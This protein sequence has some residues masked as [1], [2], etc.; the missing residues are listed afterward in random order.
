MPPLIASERALP[1]ATATVSTL[2]RVRKW[3][4]GVVDAV[5]LVYGMSLAVLMLT[6]GLDAGWLHIQ[7]A[8]KPILI[9]LLFV[10]VRIALGDQ[11]WLLRPL[12]AMRDA[13]RPVL[14][15]SVARL[16][17]AVRD[18]LFACAATVPAM[19]GVSFLVN[20]LFASGRPRPF[21]LPFAY[22]KFAETFA[23]WDSGWYFDIAKRGY[24][25]LPD[26]QSS[27]PFFPLYPLAMRTLASVFGGSDQA[28]WIS[29]IVI[30]CVSFIAGLVVLH[31]LTERICGDREVA[32]R[33]VLFLA[34]YPFSFFL[35][36]VYPG[37]LFFL[38]TVLAI[39]AAFSSRWRQ[40]GL[41]GA[42]ATLTRPHGILIAL[43]LIVLA[44]RGGTV[45]Q[46][47]MRIVALAPIPAALAGFSL[48]VAHLT[49]DPLAWLHAERA[50]GYSLWQAPWQQLLVLFGDIGQ[51]GLYLYFFSSPLAPFRLFHGA[52]ALALLMLVPTIFR[53]LGVALGAYV[54]VNL[55][56]P[57]SSN[58]LEG[59]GRY[60][61]AWF[62]IF[63]VMGMVGSPRIREAILVTSSLLLA[64]F[65]GLF[66]TWQPIY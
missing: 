34:V 46:I 63:M 7:H 59:I 18:A 30:S 13:A 60:A 58:A 12:R 19:C 14:T 50:W 6:G 37:G 66:V 56:V 3:T 10:P 26:Q 24:F 38:L 15:S 32:R 52:I 47:A 11:S 53:R 5:I 51:R 35:T 55:L 40:A 4:V 61:A 41:W 62:P 43:P 31:T 64:L 22:A 8:A 20:V 36:R 44:I 49:G 2:S 45:R 27:V 25:F 16:P 39:S 33:T 42:L 1:G 54:L 29:G 57:L 9:L 48:Y 21:T 65:V 28:I 17:P 23:A